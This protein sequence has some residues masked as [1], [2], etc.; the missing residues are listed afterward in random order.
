M[1]K[2][3]FGTAYEKWVKPQIVSLVQFIA[4]ENEPNFIVY[5][6]PGSVRFVE[7]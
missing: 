6:W 2:R 4:V 3:Y 7:P 5:V 1:T